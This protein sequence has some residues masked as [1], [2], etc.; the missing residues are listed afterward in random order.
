MT[1]LLLAAVTVTGFGSSAADRLEPAGVGRKIVFLYQPARGHHPNEESVTLF[2]HCLQTSP[3]VQG[4]R[5]E[6]HD[7][8]PADPNTLRDAATVVMYSEGAWKNGRP[9]PILTPERME[10]LDRHM[11]RGCGAVLLHYTLTAAEKVEMP[12]VIRWIGGYYSFESRESS[13]RMGRKPTPY[14]PATP[15]HAV[16]RGWK[17]FSLPHHETY[18]RLSFAERAVPILR[19]PLIAKPERA[20]DNVVAWALE[21]R[22]GGGR[23]FGYSGGHFY[24]NWL[25]DDLRTM[26]LNAIVWT[27]GM[28]VPAEGVQSTVPKALRRPTRL[29]EWRGKAD[30]TK[31]HVSHRTTEDNP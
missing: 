1:A 9:H 26:V 17:A 4:I 24:D 30:R 21:R 15:S 31:P 14:S 7:R 18:F 28:D 6:A 3:N 10:V 8:W 19:A 13:N 23:G 16:S 11:A 20:S 29:S 12:F 27:A 22:R 5:C 25:N 2:M